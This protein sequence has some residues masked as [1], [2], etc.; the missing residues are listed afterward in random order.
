MLKNYAGSFSSDVEDNFDKNREK[1]DS[2]FAS[3]FDRRKVNPLIYV[4]LWKQ[5]RLPSLLFGGGALDTYSYFV[6]KD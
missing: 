2:I 3:N 6:A 1:V 5:A 4:K